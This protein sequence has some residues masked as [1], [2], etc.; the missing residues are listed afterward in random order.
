MFLEAGDDCRVLGACIYTGPLRDYLRKLGA[1]DSPCASEESDRIYHST[2]AGWF[3]KQS[4][5]RL[6]TATGQTGSGTLPDMVLREMEDALI[7]G[8]ANATGAIVQ[9]DHHADMRAIERAEAYLCSHLTSAVS[10]ADMAME[11]GVS[12]RT[13]SRGF[14]KRH[15][16]GP[17]GF[18]K[19]RRL[20]AAYTELLGSEP[21][22]TTVTEVA[23]RYGFNHFGK[24]SIAYKR[25]FRESPS[26]TLQ[27]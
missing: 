25:A 7:A 15:G 16:T 8:F 26:T 3:L 6:W 2:A 9:S 27:Y 24:F 14:T 10:R 12:I 4:L 19:A 20:N 22:Q 21:G 18:L 1:G 13:L 11:A 17:M 23:L 5:A